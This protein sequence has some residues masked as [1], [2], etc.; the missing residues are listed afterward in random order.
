MCVLHIE[1]E[2]SEIEL[3][4]K[5]VKLPIYDFHKK[6]EKHKYNKGVVYQSNYIKCAVSDKEWNDLEGQTQDIIEFLFKY[7]NDLQ[8]IKKKFKK[9]RWQFDIPC[10]S[11]INNKTLIQNCL[12][13]SK[14][15]YESGRLGIGIN[16]S[17]YSRNQN[18]ENK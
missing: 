16:L 1:I 17:I 15:L 5:S 7:H 18:I 2:D 10:L 3:L 4:I 6:G 12:L 9:I 11:E 8:T 14:L 13:Q